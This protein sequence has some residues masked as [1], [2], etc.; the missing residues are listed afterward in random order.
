MKK[1]TK[2]E[3]KK[4]NGLNAMAKYS[5]KHGQKIGE[6]IG[7][8]PQYFNKSKP[9]NLPDFVKVSNGLPFIRQSNY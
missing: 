9:G 5:I 3:R 4:L 7:K 6:Y 2:K 8:V 1:V